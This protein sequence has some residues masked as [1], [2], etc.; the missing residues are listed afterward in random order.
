MTTQDP[1]SPGLWS[2]EPQWSVPADSERGS[3]VV[4]LPSLLRSTRGR[5]RGGRHLRTQALQQAREG[6]RRL[7]PGR[8]QCSLCR[9]FCSPQARPSVVLSSGQAHPRPGLSWPSG[10][11]GPSCLHHPDFSQRCQA[12]HSHSLPAPM[13]ALKPTSPRA[14]AQEPWQEGTGAC[15]RVAGFPLAQPQALASGVPGPRAMPLCWPR[16]QRAVSHLGRRPPPSGL[17]FHLG[18]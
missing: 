16:A 17:A 11:G 8:E 3:P 10:A 12:S 5:G 15:L 18:S 13:M 1:G 14:S 4:A 7:W 9:P 6:G 2:W